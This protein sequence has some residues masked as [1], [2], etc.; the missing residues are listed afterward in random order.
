MNA[1]IFQNLEPPQNSVHKMDEQK[2]VPSED[3]QILSAAIQNM[4]EFT[5][6]KEMW[7]E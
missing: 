2:Q 6:L 4:L 5:K 3:P 1:Q 7:P